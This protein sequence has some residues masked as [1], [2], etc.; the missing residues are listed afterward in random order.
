MSQL[1]EGEQKKESDFAKKLQEKEQEIQNAKKDIL[2]TKRNCLE[3]ESEIKELSKELNSMKG[4]LCIGSAGFNYGIKDTHFQLPNE[5]KPTHPSP[6]EKRLRPI[7]LKFQD[8][9]TLITD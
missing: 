1:Q 9:L 6:G 3:K 5:R 7:P 4:N 8:L 2:T